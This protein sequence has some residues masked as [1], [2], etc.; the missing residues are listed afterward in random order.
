[1]MI[2]HFFFFVCLAVGL[3]NAVDCFPDIVNASSA[4]WIKNFNAGAMDAVSAVHDIGGVVN[5]PGAGGYPIVGRSQIKDFF[6]QQWNFGL[7]LQHD[8]PNKKV[9]CLDD[10]NFI[11][12][13]IMIGAYGTNTPFRTFNVNVGEITKVGGKTVVNY[14]YNNF[15]IN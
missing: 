14:Y 15:G 5:P 2:S 9:I 12:Y 8:L 10:G 4:L 1:M 11:E 3:T 13:T 7:R 6:T